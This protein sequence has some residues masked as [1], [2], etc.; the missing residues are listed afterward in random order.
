MLNAKYTLKTFLSSCVR[1][2]DL[3]MPKWTW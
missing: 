3:K 2:T 1:E